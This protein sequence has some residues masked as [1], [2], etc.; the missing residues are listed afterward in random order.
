MYV[1]GGLDFAHVGKR[2]PATKSAVT[3]PKRKLLGA[4]AWSDVL[5]DIAQLAAR[6]FEIV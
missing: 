3:G 1:E 5:A 2:L 6:L 4:A